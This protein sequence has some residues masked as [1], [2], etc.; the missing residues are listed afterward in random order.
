MQCV[1][2]IVGF[3]K[4]GGG[5]LAPMLDGFVTRKDQARFLV[6]SFQPLVGF[7]LTDC[8]VVDDVLRVF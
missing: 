7:Y 3:K 4:D 8:A 2:A 1:P 5:K 6:V